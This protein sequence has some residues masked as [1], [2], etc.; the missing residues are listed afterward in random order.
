MKILTQ[1]GFECEV[2]IEKIKDWRFVKTNAKLAKASSDVD[3]LN[4]MD[5]CINILL[6]VDQ[7]EKLYDHLAK[8]TGIVDYEKV[9]SE[10]NHIVAMLSNEAKLKNS[11]ASQG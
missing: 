6:G 2:N 11:L 4:Y 3:I 7:A 10:Y 8:E 5:D 1:T 9:T